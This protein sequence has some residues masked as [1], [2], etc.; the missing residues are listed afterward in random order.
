MKKIFLN[1]KLTTRISIVI[2]LLLTVL[3]TSFSIVF[4]V[5]QKKQIVSSVDERMKQGLNDISNAVD[6]FCIRVQLHGEIDSLKKRNILEHTKMLDSTKNEILDLKTENIAKRTLI[7]QI[8]SDESKYKTLK[9]VFDRKY[10]K[11]GY[12]FLISKNGTF[13]IHPNKEKENASDKKFFKLILNSKESVGYAEYVWPEDN[14]GKRKQEY[15]KYYA[16]LDA[17]IVCTVY[18]YDIYEDLT[19]FL[20][21]LSIGGAI[22]M[23]LLA[24]IIILVFKPIK[25]VLNRM[26]KIISNFS[27]GKIDDVKIDYS[28]NDEFAEIKSNLESLK[29]GFE[30]YTLFANRIG[31]NDLNTEFEPLSTDDK[32]G[33]SLLEMKSSLI[34]A[35]DDELLRKSEDDRRNWATIGYAK[36][37][38][39]LRQNNDNIE[40]LS[41]NIIK[42]LVDYMGMNQ[43][44]L[45]IYN[46]NNKEH[47]YLE[48]AACYAFDRHKFIH[49]TI[50]IGEGLVGACYQE[51]QTIFLTNVPDNY[52]EITSGLG[53]ANPKCILIVPLKLND[54]IYGIVEMASFKVLEK[55]QIEFVEK[56]GESIASTISSVKVNIRTAE[57]LEVSQQQ[58]EEMRAQ[59]EEMRQNLEEMHA[60]QE[61][62]ARKEAEQI[63]IIEKIR[64]ESD[65]QVHQIQAQ[66][67][68]MRQNLEELQ[69]T[70]DELVKKQ[71]NEATIK[72]QMMDQMLQAEDAIFDVEKKYKKQVKALLA[73]I[74]TLKNK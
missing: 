45:F 69:A 58:A 41:F 19:I 11:L 33:K 3:F 60:T 61:E 54:Q 21:T 64:S 52:I 43:G 30:D 66:E 73:E 72:A 24:L 20:L 59:E 67:E 31:A 71:E 8:L 14:T 39:I 57:L 44:G 27:K 26:A 25:K 53:E 23:A 16:P 50:E 32:L 47:A 15:F 68:E 38:E 55:Y 1:L 74:E 29:V 28:F 12:P 9:K 36:F 18:E 6:E 46:D 51:G 48:L 40:L 56:V 2:I 13:L 22:T 62:L 17:Y 5:I 10:Y 35:H 4:Y 70:Q 34:K 49:K 7:D 37:G 42:N 65:E 63:R